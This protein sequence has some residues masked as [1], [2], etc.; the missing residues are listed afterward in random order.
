MN[1]CKLEIE[2]LPCKKVVIY[3]NKAEVKRLLEK[4]LENGEKEIIISNLSTLTDQNSIRY[5]QEFASISHL[6][7]S[8]IIF[9]VEVQDNLPINISEV[10]CEKG[11]VET[12]EP[13]I[14]QNIEFLQEKIFEYGNKEK[15]I[16]AEQK[17]QFFYFH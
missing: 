14:Y 16:I 9:R 8:V 15:A 12:N 3:K 11:R 7:F 4:R 13:T 17:R 10:K 6:K 2:K 5:M 1:A